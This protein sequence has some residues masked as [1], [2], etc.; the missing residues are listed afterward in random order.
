MPATGQQ[1]GNPQAILA[2]SG[3]LRT[4]STRNLKR[5]VVAVVIV[6]VVVVV[7]DDAV[8]VD[9][10]SVVKEHCRDYQPPATCVRDVVGWRA[11]GSSSGFLEGY[12]DYLCWLARKRRVELVELV[13][14]LVL[15]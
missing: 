15:S 7:V 5:L 3:Q 14:G 4:L 9:V 2:Q 8:A 10:A 1:Q 6:V 11:Y 13:L 12:R